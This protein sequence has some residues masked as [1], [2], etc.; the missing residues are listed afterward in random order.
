[1]ALIKCPECG[2]NVSD[3][4]AACIHCGCPLTNT[5][6]TNQ[7]SNYNVILL[8]YGK[9]RLET[10]RIIRELTGLLLKPAMK[11]ADNTPSTVVTELSKQEAERIQRNFQ[12]VGATAEIELSSNRK[13]RSLTCPSCGSTSITTGQRGY[14][15]VWGFI[16]S[17]QTMNRCAKCGHKWHPQG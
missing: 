5:E 9:N 14:N 2:G 3:K 17:G 4:A 1:M 15:I 12:N 7:A 8:S 16:G 6:N 11:L 13:E 10:I